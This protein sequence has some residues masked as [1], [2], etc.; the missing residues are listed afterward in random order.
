[1]SGDKK[2]VFRLN[3]ESRVGVRTA[4]QNWIKFSQ[5]RSKYLKKLICR[6]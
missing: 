6:N 3:L 2:E 1:M 5:N 4:H